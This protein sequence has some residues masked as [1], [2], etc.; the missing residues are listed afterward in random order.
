MG[1]T[2][3]MK[4]LAITNENGVLK[5][6]RNGSFQSSLL[7]D[8]LKEGYSPGPFAEL[9]GSKNQTIDNYILNGFVEYNGEL[10]FWYKYFQPLEN[11]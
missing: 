2:N 9:T 4:M 10:T 11:E 6:V 5:M 3:E 1:N 7:S 8:N